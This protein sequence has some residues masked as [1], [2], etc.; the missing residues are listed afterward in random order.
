LEAVSPSWSDGDDGNA[1]DGPIPQ[2]AEG[3]EQGCSTVFK[4]GAT[5]VILA[6]FEGLF[7]CLQVRFVVFFEVALSSTERLRRVDGAS[8]RGA[9]RF[10]I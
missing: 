6:F 2:E 7:V 3:S 4:A 5:T 9:D 8:V 1:A 10:S